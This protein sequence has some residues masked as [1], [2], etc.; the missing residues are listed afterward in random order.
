MKSLFT[1]STPIDWG[2]LVIVVSVFL[3]VGA[4]SL[5]IS[6][7]YPYYFSWDMDHCTVLD[8]FVLAE[9]K[10]PGHINHP[11]FGMYILFH[12]SER[13]AY[14]FNLISATTFP[15]LA[16]ALT[17]P[18]LVAE[19]TD[20][21]RRHSPALI[22]LIVGCCWLA[23][24]LIFSLGRIFSLLILTYFGTLYSLLYHSN[25][26]RSELHSILYWSA[27]LL[28][29]AIAVV[30]MRSKNLRSFAVCSVLVGV[31]AGLSLLTKFQSFIHVFVV[32]F[33]FVLFCVFSNRGNAYPALP[34]QHT[35]RVLYLALLNTAL[36]LW[37]L[38]GGLRTVVP[39]HYGTFV[40]SPDQWGLSLVGGVFLLFS[41]AL[42]VA[43]IVSTLPTLRTKFSAYLLKTWS[44]HFY[45][46]GFIAAFLMHLFVLSKVHLAYKY[47]LF[48][49][50]MIFG[51]RVYKLPQLSGIIDS[52]M[53]SASANPVVTT[54]FVLFSTGIFFRTS[55][56]RRGLVA[57]S[58]LV[59]IAV[60]GFSSRGTSRDF[61]WI[62]LFIG[63]LTV[64]FAVSVQTKTL[65]NS[66]K[67]RKALTVAVYASMLCLIGYNVYGLYYLRGWQDGLQPMRGWQR[68]MVL[69]HMFGTDQE[70]YRTL[71]ENNYGSQ[72]SPSAIVA[73]DFAR[74]HSAVTRL[75]QF[76]FPNQ[77][78]PS[79]R[80]GAAYPKFRVWINNPNEWVH[81]VSPYLSQAVLVDNADLS[82]SFYNLQPLKGDLIPH[83]FFRDLKRVLWREKDYPLVVM[84]RADSE[85]YI[86]VTDR[87]QQALSSLNRATTPIV[88]TS[89]ESIQVKI[90]KE[91][92]RVFRGIRF[93]GITELDRKL[94]ND[95]YFF[96]IRQ[97]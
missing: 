96:V 89:S 10:I 97:L 52:I 41:L 40:S 49:S 33:I 39:S 90:A 34:V 62:E 59:T 36:F 85:V 64:L 26:I 27:A 61:L 22:V 68:T 67:E 13:V 60:F 86:F 83:D 16:N 9:G 79:M 31:L 92:L 7:A 93:A 46:F 5:T 24:N 77:T 3:G 82:T 76:T 28:V 57:L 71:V 45:F 12:L 65:W 29:A 75:A 1:K 6:Q 72:T 8:Q 2:F 87:D 15:E 74:N 54:V 48:D 80:I 63:F 37:I 14:V 51:R 25:L 55:G 30:N 35:R 21:L 50:K 81:S 43:A 66:G 11:S 17:P 38:I 4:L 53:A 95:P 73:S 32:P 47:M 94:L 18:M 19:V 58:V 42:L 91:S 78:I 70:D 44:L 56:L 23:L 69:Y 88:I 20:Y 84:P